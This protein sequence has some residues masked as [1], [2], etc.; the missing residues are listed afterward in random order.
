VKDVVHA[1][2]LLVDSE[3]ALRESLSRLRGLLHYYVGIDRASGYL[4]NVSVWESLEASHQ[5]DTLQAMLAQRPV[6]EPVALFR[7]SR[8]CHRREKDKRA[9]R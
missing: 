5:M 2:Q 7:E 1:E 4:T 6:P 9:N 8:R 3:Q